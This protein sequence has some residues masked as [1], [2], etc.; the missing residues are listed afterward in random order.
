MDTSIE[1]TRFYQEGTS[2]YYDSGNSSASS[3]VQHVCFC[4]RPTAVK[5]A[6]T[7]KNLGRRLI[8]TVVSLNGLI[9]KCAHLVRRWYIVCI[10]GMN[11]WRL[12]RNDVKHWFKLKLGR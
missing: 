12:K 3:A 11:N 10:K 2:F 5:T 9:L 7:E 1:G 4:E 6:N 8:K